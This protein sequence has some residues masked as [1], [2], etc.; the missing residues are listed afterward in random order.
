MNTTRTFILAAAAATLMSV[1]AAQAGTLE[2]LE[3][4]R[5]LVIETMF[6]PSIGPEERQQKLANSQHRLVDLE[7]M[8]LRDESLKG[9]T[10]PVVIK[11]FEN[12]DLTFL[13]HS[14]VEKKE[15]L[16]DHWL[17][18]VGVLDPQP[19]ERPDREALACVPPFRSSM[20]DP[21]RSRCFSEGRWWPWRLPS[22]PP[23]SRSST[24][25]TGPG[26]CSA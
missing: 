22:W 5:A 14:S 25:P 20:P 26:T 16:V 10:D 17:D 18:Q 7:R 9:R 2:N 1:G 15:T 8:V 3:R 21:G 4:E 12:Y 11:A 24:W 23:G 13:V 6:D 19:D